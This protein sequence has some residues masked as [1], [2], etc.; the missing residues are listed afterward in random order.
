MTRG[1]TTLII[2]LYEINFGELPHILALGIELVGYAKA[3]KTSFNISTL[4]GVYLEDFHYRITVEH[5]EITHPYSEQI[6]K[7]ESDRMVENLL[8][9]LFDRIRLKSQE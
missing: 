2:F 6:T 3:A 1:E 7:D 4:F 8:K 9:A 5:F